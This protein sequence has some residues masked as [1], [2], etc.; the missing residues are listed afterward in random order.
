MIVPQYWAEGRVRNR[1]GQRQVT[2]RRF[3]WSDVS[4]ADAQANAD[5]RAEAALARVVAGEQ[6]ARR[7]P[8]L[9]Y[10][11]ADGVPIREEIVS[12]H[13]DAI[14]TR[15]TYGARCLNTPDVLFADVDFKGTT[16][17][18]LALATVGLLLV[19]VIAVAVERRSVGTGVVGF[20]L[21]LFLGHYAANLIHRLRLSRSG[22]VEKQARGRIDAF[23]A[24]HP[25][26]HL[27]IYRTPAG[28]RLLAMHRTFAPNDSAVAE[29][30][31]SLQ[32]DP[33]YARMCLNQS[34]FRARVSPKPW[35]IGIG[36]H[37]RP[38]PGVWPV[39]PDKL[40]ERTRWIEVYEHASLGHAACSFVEAVG[41]GA[42]HS[43]ARAVQQLHDDLCRATGGLPIA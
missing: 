1:V 12:R 35:R 5:R 9:S 32:V 30:F 6:I 26:W 34:C 7:E 10:N 23:M 18:A 3:G 20:L 28:Y 22:G 16:P 15:N 8:K 2:L 25:D 37:I 11:G 14:V 31:R 41:N 33:V 21:A 36:N 4:Q 43:S 42:V 24:T 27:R 13:G 19:A 17:V 40:P 39:N 38:R 29:C